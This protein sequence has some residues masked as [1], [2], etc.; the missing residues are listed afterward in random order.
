M[1]N[2]FQIHFQSR[3]MLKLITISVFDSSVSIWMRI[4]HWLRRYK[5]DSRIWY[6]LR[7]YYTGYGIDLTWFLRTKK[8]TDYER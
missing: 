8:S 1:K 7:L 6:E 3:L 4:R 5:I 2:P